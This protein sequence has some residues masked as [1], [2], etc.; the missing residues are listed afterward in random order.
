MIFGAETLKLQENL[1]KYYM[2]SYIL[3]QHNN[4]LPVSK[5]P[6]YQDDVTSDKSV[7]QNSVTS[8][9]HKTVTQVSVTR[10]TFYKDDRLNVREIN[11]PFI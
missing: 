9:C 5:E 6:L 1:K 3:R 4:V 8:Q 2:H 11:S 10:L 7:S